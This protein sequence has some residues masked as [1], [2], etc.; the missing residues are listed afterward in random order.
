MYVVVVGCGKVG[1][2]LTRA[3]LAMGHETLTIEKDTH[4]C[5]T[6]RDEFGSVGLQGDGTDVR[7]LKEAGVGRADVLVAVA[8]RDEDNLAACQL[9]K[10]YFNTPTTMALVKDPQNEA[11]FKLLGVDI[12]IN[13]THLILSF[14]E[15]EIPGH[16]L[17]HLTNLK[18]LRL[19]MISINIPADATV[20]G[21]SLGDIELPPNTIISLL[22]K[23][24][25]PILPSDGVLL[26]PGDDVV[27]VT[28]PEEE[29]RLYDTLTGVD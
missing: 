22:V 18:A 14:I 29:Q 4:R 15:E 3:L 10:H 11:L 5:Q 13:S 19:E 20:V 21:K 7:V 2:D 6:L 12:A 17:V 25:G 26:G 27:V 1:Y 8:A 9:A 28:S 23:N 24:D 16:A